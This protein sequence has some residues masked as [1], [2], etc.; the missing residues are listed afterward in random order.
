[1]AKSVRKCGERRLRGGTTG[2][3]LA[4]T[5]T[6]H[7]LVGNG[8]FPL[9]PV[10]L[11]GTIKTRGDR[12]HGGGRGVPQNW[13]ESGRYLRRSCPFWRKEKR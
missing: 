12:G 11:K 10:T 4:E 1:V 2:W 13:E 7:Y 6:R 3:Y 8:R 9:A 5:G